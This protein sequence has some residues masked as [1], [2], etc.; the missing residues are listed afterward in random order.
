MIL[1]GLLLLLTATVPS[2]F[3]QSPSDELNT[4]LMHSTFM[5]WGHQSGNPSKSVV[6]TGFF[7]GRPIPGNTK[8][9]TYVLVTAAHVLD[10][11]GGGK[12]TMLLRR[13]N[14][15][16]NYTPFDVMGRD[17]RRLHSQIR[18]VIQSR[19]FPSY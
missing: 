2:T 7:L 14:P 9:A 15:D 6:G 19:S 18:I 3:A 12:A 10:E 17:N 16:G 4:L 8:E 13:R 1:M 11:I 5:I